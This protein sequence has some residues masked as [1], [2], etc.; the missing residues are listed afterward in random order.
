MPF[1]LGYLVIDEEWHFVQPK[2]IT[3]RKIFHLYHR[4]A[5][6]FRFPKTGHVLPG[7]K[8]IQSTMSVNLT[9]LEGYLYVIIGL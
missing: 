2:M 4:I 8:V 5:L 6:A 3:A 7:P 1:L 9:G